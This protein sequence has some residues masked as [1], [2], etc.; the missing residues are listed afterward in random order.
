ME[1]NYKE[2][3]KKWQ[4]YWEK[5]NSYLTKEDSKNPKFYVLDMFPYP[6]GEGLHVGHPKGYIATDIIARVKRAQGFNVLHP[7]GWD[8]FGL[9]AENYAIKTGIHPEIITEKNISNIKR[10][11]KM[12]GLSYDWSREINTTSPEYY[13]WT[14]WIFLKLYENGLAYKKLLP[15]NWCPSCKTGLAN[16]EVVD[17]KCE[18]CGTETT[19]KDIEQWVLKITNYADKLLEG[20]DDIDWPEKIKEMQKNWIGRSEGWEIKFLIDNTKEISVFTTRVDTLF[21]CTYLVLAPEHPLI[22]ELQ[23]ENKKEVLEYI[24]KAKNKSERERISEVKDKTGVE[25]KGIKA[26]NPINGKEIRV[27]IADY[28]LFH[29]GT[30]AVMAVPA[31][32]ERDFDF[33]NKYGLEIIE[34]IKGKNKEQEKAFVEDGILF[35]SSNFDNL[36]SEEG[37]AKI[38]EYLASQGKAEKKVN[39]KLRDWVFS[40][41]RY[42]GEPIPIIHCSK[43]GMVAVPE[44]ELPLKLPYIERY[45]P[46]GTGESPLAA[47]SDWVNVK[48]P[49]CGGDAKRETNTMPQ[50]A[51]SC[52]YYLRYLDNKNNE[53][54]FD[55]EIEKKWMPVDLYVGGAEHA[56]LHLLYSRFWHKFLYDIKVVST[57]E[58]FKK[59]RNIGL[60]LAFDGQK[61]SKSKGNIVSPDVI[62]DEFG[63]DTLRAYE[64]FMGP[65]DQAIQWNEQGVKGVNRFLNKAW[66]IIISCKDNKT[67]SAEII[68]MVHKL[69]KKV[70]DDLLKMKFNTPI[71]FFMEFFNYI[72]EKKDEFGKDE[73]ERILKLLSPFVPHFCEELWSILGNKNSILLEKW[74]E[75]DL[76]LI[77]EEKVI[78]IVQVNGKM[79]EKI[80]VEVDTQKEEVEKIVLSNEKLKKWLEGKEIKEIFFVENKLINICVV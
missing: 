75:E 30:G 66:D 79:R 43:C 34:V 10:Q 5:N 6:S 3:E 57:K 62:V 22:N 17:G 16:E 41:Q 54:I 76:S 32:D 80:E 69:N 53:E 46:T 56:V 74:P 60:I 78:M 38:G 19:K 7:M 50:W 26:I 1:Y 29:Y 27:F 47:I 35:N 61:M 4:D 48:C 59:L 71:A 9:P 63:A 64:M 65:F 70:S 39:Y 55:K 8:A 2:I 14:Q 12:I 24:N 42:W 21:G 31:H 33:A 36:T 72:S 25:L 20:L 73:I 58:P 40:R 15:I 77:K 37:R 45:Q 52:W 44:N 18:R 49:K 51:G 68:A 67:S 28:V 23:I 13:K 11:M